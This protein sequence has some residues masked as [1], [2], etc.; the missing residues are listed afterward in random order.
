M[1]CLPTITPEFIRRMEN[2]LKLYAKPYNPQE[3]VICFDEKSKQL[4]KDTRK[5]R[6][7]KPGK[8]RRRDYEYERNGVRNIFLAV[9]PK[10]G[11]RTVSVTKHR[12]KPD[13]AHEIER[14]ITLPRYSAAQKIH[15]VVDNLNTH[16]EK[17]FYET[18]EKERAD[19]ILKRIQFRY[20]PKHASW[21]NMA[22]IELSI[23]GRQCVNQRIPTEPKLIRAITAWEQRRNQSQ[24][25]INWKFTVKDARNV[26]KYEQTKLS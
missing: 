21:L 24:S 2:L 3:P 25:K 6:P 5:G 1:W 22:E 26:F 11:F 20:T 14:I 19:K 12:K 7:T 16:F 23:M 18:F 13:L 4:L 15:I 17:S 9:E 8:P 10:A